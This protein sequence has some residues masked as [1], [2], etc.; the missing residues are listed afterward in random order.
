MPGGD[1]TG[2][3]GE[4]PLTGR[5]MGNC[6]GADNT[7]FFGRGAGRRNFGGGMGRG[8][9]GR[10][11]GFNRF[12]GSYQDNSDGGLI[13]SLMNRISALEEKLEN[14]VRKNKD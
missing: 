9:F 14:A 2:P 13:S 6:T 12:G 8:N 7:G 11:R 4:G 10:G 1:K 5:R 3:M